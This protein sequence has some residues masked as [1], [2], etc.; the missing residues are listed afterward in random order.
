M[1]RSLKI[2]DDQIEIAKLAVRKN[3]FHSQRT[4]AED[5]GFSLATVSNFLTG[6]PVDYSTFIELCSH[7]CLNWKEIAELPSEVFPQQ[8]EDFAKCKDASI[9]PQM[10]WQQEMKDT[11]LCTT[12]Q[13]L[14]ILSQWLVQE[15]CRLISLMNSSDT[16]SVAL[17]MQLKQQ[18]HQDFETVIGRS[19]KSTPDAG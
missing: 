2:S 13:E 14:V 9:Q 16:N 17:V 12:T 19:L 5:A 7:L 11:L 4:L 6:K 3:G 1:P 15:S 10:A 8:L 18:V